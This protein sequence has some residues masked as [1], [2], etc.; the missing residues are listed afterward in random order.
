MNNIIVVPNKKEDIDIIL[1]KDIKGIIIGV[2][3]LSIYNFELTI[4]EIILLAQSVD[5]KII[6]AMNKMIHNKDIPLVKEVLNKAATSNIEGILFYDIG[7]FKVAKDMNIKKELI[8][9]QEHLNAS[10]NSNNFYYN[11]GLN[12]TYI[13]SDITKEE[14]LDIKNNTK[15]NIYYTVYGLLPIFYSRRLLLTSYFTYINKEKKDNLYCIYNNDNKYTII[16]KKYGTIIYSP[17]VN[18]INHIEEL[19]DINLVIDLSSTNN[20]DIIDKYISKEKMEN[21]YEGFYNI[22]TIYR[23]KGDKDA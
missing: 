22:K 12:S 20:I 23:L 5:K 15:L 13:T 7:I 2:K 11:H 3:D 18:L 6:I 16:E 10:I 14:I 4:E 17:L 19:K 8:L 21:T 1:N 9:S